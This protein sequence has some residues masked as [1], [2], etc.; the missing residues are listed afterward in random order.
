MIRRDTYTADGEHRWLLIMQPEHARL[1]G[2]LAESWGAAPFAPVAPRDELLA[3]IYQ[4]DDGWEPWEQSPQV[5]PQTGRPLE[6]TEMPLADSLGIWRGSILAVCRFG[7]LAPWLVA[8]H[9]SA[10]L[11]SSANWRNAEGEQAR[12]ANEFLQEQD[13]RRSEWLTKWLAADPRRHTRELADEGL[14]CLQFFDA[15]S[16]WLCCAER[17]LPHTFEPPSGPPI[18]IRPVNAVRF[19]AEPWPFTTSKLEL[20]VC[21]RSVAAVTYRTADEFAAADSR[22]VELRWIVTGSVG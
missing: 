4:H 21:G 7:D 20:A 17:W 18:T 16:L 1:S 11:R 3:A 15:L 9:F 14:R 5:D 2:L 12:I 10:L 8:G 6:F 22:Q 19:A 13:M